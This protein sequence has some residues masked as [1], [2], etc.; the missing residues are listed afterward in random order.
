MVLVFA[1]VV[2]VV[3]QVQRV[4]NRPCAEAASRDNPVA[5]LFLVV[6]D[7]LQLVGLAAKVEYPFL[8]VAF[9]SVAFLGRVV[10]ADYCQTSMASMAVYSADWVLNRVVEVVAALHLVVV[11]YS[12]VV[13]AIACSCRSYC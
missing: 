10:V 9:V 3:V 12:Q 8:V 2:V 1:V 11:A 5:V 7:A 6:V 13:V 4:A